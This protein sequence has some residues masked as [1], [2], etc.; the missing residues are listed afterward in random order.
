MEENEKLLIET[1]QRAKS[2]QR[3]LD[4][5][6]VDALVLAEPDAAAEGLLA[7]VRALT[8]QGL[9]VRVEA[10]RPAKLRCGKCYRYREGG[11]EEC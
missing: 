9:R 3:R 2:N 10:E 6:D 11:L 7:A 5:L 4:E 8:A 1:A